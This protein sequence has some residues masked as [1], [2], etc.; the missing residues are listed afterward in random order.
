MFPTSRASS[1]SNYRESNSKKSFEFAARSDRK[2]ECLIVVVASLMFLPGLGA[3]GILNTTD[4]YYT[5]AARE[6]LLRGDFITP[7]LN[8]TPYYFKPILTYW[9]IIASYLV[10]G[11]N[12]FAA[13]LPSALSCIATALAIF[14]LTKEFIGRR[15]ALMAA[16]ALVSMPLV[17]VVG[18]VSIPDTPLLL[19]ITVSSLLLLGALIRGDKKG[20]I[21][22]YICLGLAM[23][24]KGPLAVAFVG[25]C[26]G[27]FLIASSKSLNHFKERLLSLRP[28]L[29][30]AVPLMVALPWFAAVHFVSNG[31]FT[32]FFFIQQN[33]G[34]LSGQFQSH[35]NPP[36]F[37]LPYLAGGFLPWLPMLLSAPVV[38]RP[39]P[40]KRFSESPRVQ[41]TIASLCW[42]FGTSALL[43]VSSSKVAH[44]LLPIAPPIAILTGLY[45]DA[46][47][48]LGR[49]RFVLWVAPTMVLAGIVSL[50][51][52]PRLFEDERQ[53]QMI[54]SVFV[55]LLIV[56]Y[57]AYGAFIYK[58]QMRLGV[59]LLFAWSLLDCGLLVPVSIQQTY[60][61]ANEEFVSL[62]KQA[63]RVDNSVI[64]VRANDCATAAFYAGEKI[65]EIEGPMD[66][67]K[68]VDSTQGPRYFI[69]DDQ[70]NALLMPFIPGAP[71]VI[72]T[73][74]KWNLLLVESTQNSSPAK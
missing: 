62:V 67:K 32:Q 36:W 66:C 10:L 28:F 16:L 70:A 51:V 7:Y 71:R 26:I 29:A 38:L 44:Y 5:E 20:L 1:R 35:N 17:S 40:E 2:L 64:G 6:M 24:S 21:P 12:T 53:L 23:L 9:L 25:A 45:F 33:F 52:F 3:T 68:F 27:G 47:L 49:R 34:R 58:S 59:A 14:S 15:A 11:V 22:A 60:R 4:A 18:H 19:L 39:R 43:L 65:Y 31:A 61:R 46:V 30:V 42:L 55:T 8:Y 73:D 41:I 13:R 54:A 74:G 50:F 57:T 69:L 63:S 37:Y 72:S 56:G 48:K